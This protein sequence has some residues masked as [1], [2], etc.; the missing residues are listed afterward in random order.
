MSPSPSQ[1]P[2]PLPFLLLLPLPHRLRT[3]QQPIH[4]LQPPHLHPLRPRDPHGV[5]QDDLDLQRPA[6]LPVE[7]HRR[8]G[9]GIALRA[10]DDPLGRR[11]PMPLHPP[12]VLERA[13]QHR[14]RRGPDLVH[15]AAQ[16]GPQLRV[17]QHVGVAPA[18]GQHGRRVERGVDAQ[19]VP[20][21]RL[22]A[23][24]RQRL[25]VLDAAQPRQPP[26]QVGR[27]PRAPLRERRPRVVV[28]RLPSASLL[29]AAAAV[30]VAVR[31]RVRERGRVGVGPQVHP[32]PAV[33]PDRARAD[34]LR[35]D[36]GHG[37]DDGRPREPP[38]VRVLDA[39]AVLDQH[40][41]RA[42]PHE[43]R[44]GGR[45]VAAVR[46]RLGGHDNEVPARAGRCCRSRRR[47]RRR[48]RAVERVGG[49]R[50]GG[51]RY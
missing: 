3:P 49:R 31:V 26:R 45:V 11:V 19:L 21:H 8:P 12:G 35:A 5:A 7:Q 23:E 42:G 33:L 1:L 24:L 25:G 48:R 38:A 40:D 17:R 28:R 30:A 43:R 39:H 13:A 29:L 15:D 4:A 16:V 37:A 2:L 36:D 41:G 50:R 20:P 22:Q 51:G 6:G 47:R 32:R 34:L 18:A 46:Q 10:P 44:D 9:P 27:G 14:R